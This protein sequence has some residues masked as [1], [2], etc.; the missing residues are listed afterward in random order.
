[1][2]SLFWRAGLNVYKTEYSA[3]LNFNIFLNKSEQNGEKP[4]MS[5]CNKLWFPDSYISLQPKFRRTM[6]YSNITH[7]WP[8]SKNK[9]NLNSNRV[10]I[11]APASP[12]TCL[13]YL[14]NVRAMQYKLGPE[15]LTRLGNSNVLRLPVISIN[16]SLHHQFGKM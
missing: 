14:P 7:P 1:M 2:L 4:Q 10:N 5:I 12:F 6:N 13:L 3:I 16:L 9:F 15:K 11:V 8:F